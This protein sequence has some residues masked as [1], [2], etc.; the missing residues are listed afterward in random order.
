MAVQ[1]LLREAKRF[2]DR[3]DAEFRATQIRRPMKT[4]K[5][6]LKNTLRDVLSFNAKRTP[7][8]LNKVQKSTKRK[9]LNNG[10]SHKYVKV[11]KEECK[12]GIEIRQTKTD[13]QKSKQDEHC[14]LDEKL[15]KLCKKK[16]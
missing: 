13:V 6:F 8:A 10:V 5:P 7:A 2:K 1:E 12:E 9:L 15:T 14:V 4:N 3:R 11:N 16:H